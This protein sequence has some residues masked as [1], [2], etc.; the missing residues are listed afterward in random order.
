MIKNFKELLL[1]IHTLPF[2][3]QKIILDTTIM[4]WKGD[5]EKQ[6]DDILVMGMKV[7]G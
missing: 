5:H 2:D 4:D 3:E 1:K 7:G 6:L